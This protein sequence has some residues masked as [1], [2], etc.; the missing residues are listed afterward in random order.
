MSPH[1]VLISILS[2]TALLIIVSWFTSRKTDNLT[3]FL[4][5][6]ASPW[7]V[8]AYGMIGA[9]ISG[10]TF[11]SI[12]GDVGSTHFSYMM[13]VF[14]YLVGYFVIANV[15]LP[16]YYRLNLTSIYSYLDQ[17]FGKFSYKTGSSFFLL[18]RLIGSSF[19]MFLAVN[20]LHIFVFSPWGMPFWVTAI[21][22]IVFIWIYTFRSGIKTIVW[23]DT[24]QTTFLITAVITTI[25]VIASHMDMAASG[26]FRKVF[27]SDYSQIFY[28]SWRHPHFF[29]K[30]FFAGA[31]IAIVMT[32]LDQDM[33]QKNLS[34]KNISDAKKNVY[35]L[36]IALVPVNFLFL[37][38][39]AMLYLFAASQGIAVPER[40]DDLYPVIALNYL[41]PV[42]ALT[43]VIGIISAAYSSADGTLTALTTV[44]TVDILGIEKKKFGNDRKSVRFRYLMHMMI[45]LVVMGVIVLF[46]AINN[47]SVISQLFTIAGYTYGPLLGMYAFGLFT[48]YQ[49][50]DRWVPLVAVLAPVLCYFLSAYDKLLLNGYNFG[51]E[52]LI[53]NGIFT[54]SGLWILRRKQSSS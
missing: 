23:T 38:M 11:I 35:S 25:F 46:Q 41:G 36:G 3:F 5:N 14:G 32:G 2:Y 27:E 21:I 48:R 16:L 50:K 42:A 53:I 30:D 1:I 40:T 54:F 43:F 52:L 28:T 6:R 4:G 47:E 22:F 8:V 15:L 45:S 7:F 17:R 26:L 31:F 10:V 9:S 29:L 51:F 20:V 37:S 34:C 33:M 49:V 44:F 19:R 18:S 39:G 13:I 12:P 24:L